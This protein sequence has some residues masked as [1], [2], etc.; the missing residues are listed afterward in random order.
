MAKGL[1]LTPL[2]GNS[3]KG[4]DKMAAYSAS[5]EEK[6]KKAEEEKKHTLKPI[7]IPKLDSSF[8]ST[9]KEEETSPEEPKKEPRQRQSVIPSQAVVSKEE[10]PPAF[11]Q[12]YLPNSRPVGRPRK[13]DDPRFGVNELIR[14]SANTKLYL[15]ALV[16]QRF[17][18]DSMNDIV[19]RLVESYVMN[20]MRKEERDFLN[21]QHDSKMEDI[22]KKKKY[23]AYFND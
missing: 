5:S 8:N 3:K 23:R 20:E 22:K 4:I 21:E 13:N 2:L 12:E 17:V 10:D 6:V 11:V 16:D 9:K 19:N 7:N 14:L 15:E 1:N 18:D